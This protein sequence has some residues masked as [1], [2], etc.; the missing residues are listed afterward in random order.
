LFPPPWLAVSEGPV[1]FNQQPWKQDWP[2]EEQVLP[3]H[4]PAGQH[5]PPQQ[6]SPCAQQ[7]SPHETYLQL[8]KV[9]P[10]IVSQ[11]MLAPHMLP[12]FPQF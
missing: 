5:E 6:V 2:V 1:P 9:A 3:Q 10:P 11:Y 7:V 12:H 4:C 8:H